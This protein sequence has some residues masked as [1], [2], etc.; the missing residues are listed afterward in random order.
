MH[1]GASQD[2]K[3][4]A[5]GLCHANMVESAIWHKG[6]AIALGRHC[7]IR[8]GDFAICVYGGAERSC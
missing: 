7:Q 2:A 6:E 4:A 8:F 5:S 1:E 3:V